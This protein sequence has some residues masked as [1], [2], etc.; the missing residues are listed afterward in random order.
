M[1]DQPADRR[2]CGRAG[3][4]DVVAGS[5]ERG[6]D[7]RDENWRGH[8]PVV[9]DDDRAGLAPPGVGRGKLDDGPRIEPVAHDPPQTRDTGDP[10][11]A[12]AHSLCP[13]WE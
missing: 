9:A 10:C 12:S 7:R 5:G 2:R 11:A 3:E 1:T 8:S 6:L 13:S 4:D